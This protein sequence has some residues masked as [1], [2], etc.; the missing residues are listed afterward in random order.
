M[1]RLCVPGLWVLGL[2]AGK[3][4]AGRPCVDLPDLEHPLERRAGTAGLLPAGPQR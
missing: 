1:V 4:R 2:C 3:M